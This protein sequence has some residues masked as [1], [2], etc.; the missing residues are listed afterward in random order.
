MDPRDNEPEKIQLASPKSLNLNQIINN[1]LATSLKEKPARKN[2]R[3][4]LEQIIDN[5]EKFKQKIKSQLLAKQKDKTAKA[6]DTSQPSSSKMN[7][8]MNNLS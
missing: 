8:T 1:Y 3:K 5:Q 7:I 2:P 4:K 6:G